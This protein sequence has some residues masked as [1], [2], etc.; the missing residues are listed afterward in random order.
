MAGPVTR[1]HGYLP[2]RRWS[3]RTSMQCQIERSFVRSTAIEL[4]HKRRVRPTPARPGLSSTSLCP[5]RLPPRPCIQNADLSSHPRGPHSSELAKT[6]THPP[7]TTKLHNPRRRDHPH[8]QTHHKAARWQILPRWPHGHRLRR[9]WL[10]RPIHC[11]TAGS[12]RM[13]SRGT[14]PR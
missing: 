4:S 7:P 2:R 6:Q 1:D 3:F 13:S 12:P 9:V 14:L 10:P 5:L 11:A 8:R